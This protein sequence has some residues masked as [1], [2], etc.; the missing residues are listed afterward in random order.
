MAR[1][2]FCGAVT[3][4]YVGDLATCGACQERAIEGE[5]VTQLETRATQPGGAESNP[6]YGPGRS[7]ED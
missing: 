6:S 4:E 3:S 7:K 1:C 2:Q 5:K